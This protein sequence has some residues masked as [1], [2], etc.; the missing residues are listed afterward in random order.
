MTFSTTVRTRF[1][2][3]N[4]YGGFS[5]TKKKINEVKL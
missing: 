3:L 1:F 5:G 4:F 2:V